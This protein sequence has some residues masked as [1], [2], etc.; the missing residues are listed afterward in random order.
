M[1]ILV[2]NKPIKRTICGKN[3]YSD[4]DRN[5]KYWGKYDTILNY[6]CDYQVILFIFQ[7][8]NPSL[9]HHQWFKEHCK[10]LNELTKWLNLRGSHRI[11]LII[12][13]FLGKSWDLNCGNIVLAY[14]GNPWIIFSKQHRNIVVFFSKILSYLCKI[15]YVTATKITEY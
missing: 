8:I 10:V 15:Y 12:H 5:V 3:W 1:K 7:T 14:F 9:I 13:L 2:S 6:I 11:Y 4:L